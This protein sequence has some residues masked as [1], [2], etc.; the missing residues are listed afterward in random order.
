MLASF[1]V[2][3]DTARDLPL[4]LMQC[5]TERAQLQSMVQTCD[6]E[7][8]SLKGH[9]DETYNEELVAARRYR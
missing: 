5:R 1:D 9:I 6:T 7:I 2:A 3:L 8:E 4:R